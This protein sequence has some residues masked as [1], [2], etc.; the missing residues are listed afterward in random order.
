[1]RHGA[2]AAQTLRRRWAADRAVARHVSPLLLSTDRRCTMRSC[3]TPA[4]QG[5][6]PWPSCRYDDRRTHMSTE[7]F[8]D[9]MTNKYYVGQLEILLILSL[10][11]KKTQMLLSFLFHNM[12]VPFAYLGPHANL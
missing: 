9:L 4:V 11:Q 8:I 10:L 5:A 6:H 7:H 3:C 12:F 2:A 1:M